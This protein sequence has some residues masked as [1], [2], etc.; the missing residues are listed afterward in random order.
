M[1]EERGGRRR[2]GWTRFSFL[3]EVELLL[4]GRLVVVLLVVGRVSQNVAG[5]PRAYAYGGRELALVHADRLRVLVLPF[6]HRAS[7][8]VHEEVTHRRRLQAELS[9]D[10]HLHLLRWP[11]CLLEISEFFIIL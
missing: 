9:R 2:R 10:C 5:L 3:G 8:S 4:A 11:L 7:A 6:V 1:V